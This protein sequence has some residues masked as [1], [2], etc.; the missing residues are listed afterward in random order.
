MKKYVGFEMT[1][2]DLRKLLENNEDASKKNVIIDE[3]WVSTPGQKIVHL[4][5]G[6]GGVL[7]I[8][9]RYYET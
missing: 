2:N 5:I 8:K 3:I 4:D 1:V 7:N 9:G 6:L